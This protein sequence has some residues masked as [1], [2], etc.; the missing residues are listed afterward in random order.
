[1]D[2]SEETAKKTSSE[3]LNEPVVSEIHLQKRKCQHALL[4]I[5]MFHGTTRALLCLRRIAK[6]IMWLLSMKSFS[7]QRDRDNTQILAKDVPSW[8]EGGGAQA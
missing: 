5:V 4:C 6:S 3:K 2:F 1:M 8:T 7:N